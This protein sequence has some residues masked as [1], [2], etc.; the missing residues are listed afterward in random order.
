MVN[1]ILSEEAKIEIL[2]VA[3]ERDDR[4][5]RVKF[6]VMPATKKNLEKYAKRCDCSMMFI[7][8]MAWLQGHETLK[9]ITADQVQIHQESIEQVVT[10]K[11]VP[12][13]IDID[14]ELKKDLQKD[15]DQLKISLSQYLRLLLSLYLKNLKVRE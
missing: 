1:A 6:Y 4:K 3:G 13:F 7:C 15:A 8:R 12:L 14:Y 5:K 11:G 9:K 10:K 2:N